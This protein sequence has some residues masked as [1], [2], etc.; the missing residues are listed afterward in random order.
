M[1][2]L[3]TCHKVNCPT[4]HFYV[5]PKG[6]K[7]PLIGALRLKDL[8][9][10]LPSN[11]VAEFSS[12]LQKRMMETQKDKDT[13]EENETIK[14]CCQQMQEQ[15]VQNN[16][17]VTIIE[18]NTNI[19]DYLVVQCASNHQNYIPLIEKK[20]EVKKKEKDKKI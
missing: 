3:I 18:E 13:K 11:V 6:G 20:S 8:M 2:F 14:K 12:F 17:R 19:I 7:I 5:Y 1:M 10:N 9:G 15:V 16:S 4:P